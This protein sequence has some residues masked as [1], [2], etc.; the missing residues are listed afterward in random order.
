MFS[1]WIIPLL[2]FLG[3]YMASDTQI[4][5]TQ[6]IRRCGSCPN[7][8]EFY[9]DTIHQ[10]KGNQAI[11][12]DSNFGMSSVEQE[13]S[14]E[15]VFLDCQEDFNSHSHSPFLVNCDGLVIHSADKGSGLDSESPK[16]SCLQSFKDFVMTLFKMFLWSLVL[17]VSFFVEFFQV[18]F[19]KR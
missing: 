12:S 16:T 11:E 4:Q 3:G 7:L 6:E 17:I 10:F 13:K 18:I 5:L 2:I 8:K 14:P 9:P 19:G 1:R 15:L